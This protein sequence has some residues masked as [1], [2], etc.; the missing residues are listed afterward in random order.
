[1]TFLTTALICV[2]GSSKEKIATPVNKLWKYLLN[3]ETNTFSRSNH[4]LV[5]EG[6]MTI[7]IAPNNPKI[8]FCKTL[9]LRPGMAYRQI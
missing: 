4:S 9:E 6:L 8:M 5:F 3:E 7:N 2:V 1:M